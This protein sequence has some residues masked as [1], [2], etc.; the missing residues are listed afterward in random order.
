MH[1]WVGARVG[2]LALRLRGCRYDHCYV[3]DRV[4]VRHAGL[5]LDVAGLVYAATLRDPRSG[6]TMVLHTTKPGVQAYTANFLDRPAPFSR[7]NAVCLETQF[8]PDSVK[9]PAWPSPVLRPG[10]SYKHT[11][12]HSFAWGV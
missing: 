4:P 1:L 6:R 8:Y 2:E 9:W 12:V 3:L 7:H 5:S 11:T 10:Q